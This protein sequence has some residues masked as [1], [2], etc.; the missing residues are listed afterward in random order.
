MI[1]SAYIDA[2]HLLILVS[3]STIREC[4]T[5]T[6]KDQPI[7]EQAEKNR[8][9]QVHNCLSV[10][11][12]ALATEVKK[13]PRQELRLQIHVCWDRMLGDL[14]YWR[15]RERCCRHEREEQEVV[16]V[17]AVLG[18]LERAVNR[19]T[20]HAIINFARDKCISVPLIL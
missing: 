15:R 16:V 6:S 7:R 12:E 3:V 2:I 14:C 17:V 5:L 18:S 1:P 4:H 9:R 20:K 8:F 19:T 13:Q 10:Y 11:F